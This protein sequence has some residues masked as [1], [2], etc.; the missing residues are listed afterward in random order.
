MPHVNLPFEKLCAKQ[1]LDLYRSLN[2]SLQSIC[3]FVIT[4]DFGLTIV[5]PEPYYVK[6]RRQLKEPHAWQDINLNKNKDNYSIILNM[7][8]I[9]ALKYLGVGMPTAP[10]DH[11]TYGKAQAVAVGMFLRY[12]K[13][14][15]SLSLYNE[16]IISGA[17]W[18][19]VCMFCCRPIIS[20]TANEPL[21]DQLKDLNSY[22]DYTNKNMEKLKPEDIG[23]V[24]GKAKAF[25]YRYG[26]W[27]LSRISTKFLSGDTVRTKVTREALDKLNVR[28][29]VTAAEVRTMLESEYNQAKQPPPKNI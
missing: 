16:A 22:M 24:D 13:V 6:M 1:R 20:F 23:L 8:I 14:M 7:G 12:T 29:N 19:E 18:A 25:F 17:N 15:S 27:E 10:L 26:Y 2:I 21:G 9:L 3:K 4:D 11:D 5:N 28:L